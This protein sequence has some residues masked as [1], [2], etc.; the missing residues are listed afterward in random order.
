[1]GDQY[2]ALS[3]ARLD[4]RFVVTA[5]GES[6]LHEAPRLEQTLTS[7]AAPGIDLVLEMSGITFI[8]STTINALARSKTVLEAKGSNLILQSPSPD[9]RRVLQMAGVDRGYFEIRDG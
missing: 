8:D 9:I 7:L 1:M 3:A 5:S 2:L 4:G 6:D